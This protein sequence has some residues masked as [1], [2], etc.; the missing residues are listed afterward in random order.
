MRAAQCVAA[1]TV[2][3]GTLSLSVGFFGFPTWTQ[4]LRTSDLWGMRSHV[5]VIMLD[6]RVWNHAVQLVSLYYCEV[7]DWL[8]LSATIWS[9][10]LSDPQSLCM[11]SSLIWPS[12][13][14]ATSQRACLQQTFK[15]AANITRWN[16]IH[17]TTAKIDLWALWVTNI[18][19]AASLWLNTHWSAPSVL[20]IMWG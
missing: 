9:A 12:S 4:G 17:V 20:G 19:S 5:W 15:S 10:P 11:L 18:F 8:W 7:W 2:L 14:T 6:F 13:T 16:D 3:K 1:V